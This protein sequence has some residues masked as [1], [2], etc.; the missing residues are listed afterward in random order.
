MYCIMTVM[1]GAFIDEV[2]SSIQ[3]EGVWAGQRQIFVRF[4]GCDLV[5]RYCDT[6]GSAG[7]AVS[8]DEQRSCRAQAKTASPAYEQVVNPLGP[9]VL[10]KLC[11]RLLISGPSRPVISLTGG[12]PLLQSGFLE[13]WLPS[14]RSTFTI[15]LETSGIHVREMR[16]TARLV[17]VVSMDLKLPSATGMRPFWDEH[18]AF[19]NAVGDAEVFAKSV[20]TASTS[21][22]DI[23]IAARIIADR[24]ESMPFILQPASGA[25]APSA[26]QMLQWQADALSLLADVRVIP[27]THRML[28]VP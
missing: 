3:G 1:K 16:S 6:P 18:R 19:L 14:L 2:F 4:I 26:A 24:E 27:Q 5:C 22:E 17:D 10:T 8:A 13:E 9:A 28:G 23:L 11:S 21:A 15:Y 25:H 20:I 12:E 7:A